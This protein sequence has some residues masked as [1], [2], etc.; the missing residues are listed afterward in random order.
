MVTLKPVRAL[1]WDAGGVLVRNIAPAVRSRLVERYGMTGMD[2]E[3][4]FFHNEM[5]QKAS[6]GQASDADAWEV[7]RQKLGL[8]P[9]DMPQFIEAFWSADG[10]DEELYAFTMALRPRYKVGLLS[11]ALPGTRAALGQRFPKFFEMFDVTVFSA[12]VGI[13]KPDARVYRLILDRLGVEAQEA[14]FVDDFIENV[15]G[16]RAVGLHAIQFKNSQQAISALREFF[17]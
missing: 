8:K 17:L 4:L 3:H 1:I 7:V 12:E 2:L 10:F 13:E 14:V 11:N 16:A 15:E 5:A 6:L 9:E